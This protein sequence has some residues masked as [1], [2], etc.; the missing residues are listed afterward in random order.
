MGYYPTP[1]TVTGEISRILTFAQGSRAID[2]C[3]GEGTALRTIVGAHEGVTTYGVELDTGRANK[4]A[5]VLNSVMCSDAITEVRISWGGFSLLF[6]NPPYDMSEGDVDQ[7]RTRLEYVFLK[8]HFVY[9]QDGGVLV[10][11]IPFRSIQG[12]ASYLA[13]NFT[14]LRVFPFAAGDFS[15]FKQAV[16]LGCREKDISEE[17]RENNSEYLA[18]L[19]DIPEDAAPDKL[20]VVGSE[21]FR[22]HRYT[23]IP[24]ELD[25]SKLIFTSLRFD[26]DHAYR[27][28]RNDG[29][30]NR[31][32][33]DVEPRGMSSIQ[34]L[35]PTRDGH[36]ALL[37]A[38]GFMDGEYEL[39]GN[40]VIVKGTVKKVAYLADVVPTEEGYTVKEREKYQITVRMLDTLKKQFMQVR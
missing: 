38:A 37:L 29:L 17:I 12:I 32:K 27:V 2:T 11:V 16:V 18:K 23:V 30:F 36:T 4:A 15:R 40:T 26:P 6:L 7:E 5:E 19:K 14:S 24:A 25:R 35:M 10:Y 20:P 8:H 22:A 9:L 21:E 28:I 13:R 1:E 31:W 3:C 34:P 39:D 33:L